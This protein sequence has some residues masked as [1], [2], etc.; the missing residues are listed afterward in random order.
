MLYKVYLIIIVLET[1][2]VK[3]DLSE[4]IE[5]FPDEDTMQIYPIL[6]STC[7]K[8]ENLIELNLSS[9]LFA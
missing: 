3:M 1:E 2:L 8:L 9:F 7:L 5:I 6:T 4:M